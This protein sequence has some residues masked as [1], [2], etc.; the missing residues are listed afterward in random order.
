M[1]TFKGE[2]VFVSHLHWKKKTTRA[3]RPAF[4]CPPRTRVRCRDDNR[5]THYAQTRACETK[6]WRIRQ[7]FEYAFGAGGQGGRRA[8]SDWCAN[9]ITI[10]IMYLH[11]RRT[12][13]ATSRPV[14]RSCREQPLCGVSG[15]VGTIHF[16]T[17]RKC[18]RERRR[19]EVEKD[20]EKEKKKKK[21][22]NF[23]RL[24]GICI[25]VNRGFVISSVI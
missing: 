24:F 11:T 4:E 10:Y 17:S 6:P 15:H 3:T 19:H 1:W 20:K 5:F 14:S 18:V 23:F 16:K 7:D 9:N 25:C 13:R 22:E 21:D 8:E 12:L 2:L